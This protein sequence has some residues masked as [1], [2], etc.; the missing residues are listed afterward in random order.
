[1]QDTREIRPF[2]FFRGQ[3]PDRSVDPDRSALRLSRE[4][5]ALIGK[6]WTM[7]F[8]TCLLSARIE[9]FPLQ[10]SRSFELTARGRRVVWWNLAGALAETRSSYRSFRRRVRRRVRHS[11]LRRSCCLFLPT[12][13]ADPRDSDSLSLPLCLCFARRDHHAASGGTSD[14]CL[15]PPV[16]R[17][18][19]RLYLVVLAVAVVQIIFARREGNPT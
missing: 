19:R 18:A 9:D 17:G 10:F 4:R 5:A 16:H 3:I 2:L 8:S 15:P 6:E 11:P 13:D 14:R 1:M 7:V 12:F